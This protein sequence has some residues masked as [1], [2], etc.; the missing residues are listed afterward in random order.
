MKKLSRAL[1]AAGILLMAAALIYEAANY[2]WQILFKSGEQLQEDH[3]PDPTP[4]P[5]AALAH[6]VPA[7][8]GPKEDGSGKDGLEDGDGPLP[9]DS[10]LLPGEGDSFVAGFGKASAEALVVLGAI[11][12]PKLSISVNILQG[13]SQ[14]TLLYG[15]GHVT[16]S[17]RIGAKGNVVIAGHRVTYVMHPFRHLDKMEPG[18]TVILK[19]DLHTYIYQTLETFIIDGAE[20]WVMEKVED[21]PYC[22]TLITCH[23]VGSAKQRLILRAALVTVDGTPYEEYYAKPPVS[24]TPE[25]TL[26]GA[27]PAP[28]ETPSDQKVES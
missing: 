18:D 28:D 15:A 22:L 21:V 27:E 3:M 25:P 5:G 17:A 13:T 4:P 11:K 24:E 12:I 16:G 26:S 2:P 10:D 7:D 23:P 1:I 14:Q 6:T 8:D 19:D 9:E 20:T